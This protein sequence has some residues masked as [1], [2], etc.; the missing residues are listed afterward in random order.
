MAIN[1]LYIPLFNIEEVILDKDSGLPLAAGVVKFY[2]DSQRLTPK[3]V[4]QIAG[5]SPNYS[6]VSLG[7]ELTLGLSGT[8]V[9]Q[10]GDPMVPYAYPYDSEGEVDLYYVTV[11]S[12]GGIP[13][14]VRQA[15][16]H[17]DTGGISPA[18]RSSTENELS[19]PQFVEVNIPETGITTI[20]VTGSN[21]V[22]PVAPGW[23]IISTGTGT[24][25]LERLQPTSANVPTNPPFALRI[26]AS[27]GLGASI[28]LRQR[29]YNTT[30]IFRGGFASGSLTAAVIS[31]GG[32]FVTMTYAPSSGTSTEI[33]PSTSI[34]TD[35][36]YHVIAANAAIPD[37]ANPAAGT[38]Y[39][40][41]NFTLPTSRNLA[42]TSLQVVGTATSINIPYDEQPAARQ[43][44]HLF[45]YYEN[46]VVRQSK[47]SFVVGWNF[48]LNPWQLYPTALTTLTSQT[49]YTADQTIIHQATASSIKT[50]KVGEQL[51]S[52][53]GIRAI[54]GVADNRFALIQYIDPSSVE[55]YWN[56]IVSSLAKV[57]LYTTHSTQ[58]R[59]KMRLIAR[60]SLP[61]TISNTEPISS[62]PADSDPVFGAGWTAIAPMND[63]AYVLSNQT[64]LTD[65][66]A[67]DYPSFS[68]DQFNLPSYVPTLTPTG[69]NTLGVLIYTMDAMNN[70]LGTEDTIIF[71]DV[72][73]CANLF[74][75]KTQAQTY[76][77]VLRQCQFYYEKS[78]SKGVL[79]GA[80]TLDGIRYASAPLGGDYS[81]TTLYKNS[82]Q[83]IFNQVKRAIPNMFF[84]APDGTL[85]QVRMGVWNGTAYPAPGA[86]SNPVNVPITGWDAGSPISATPSSVLL[87]PVNATAI[88]SFAAV[89]GASQG[90]IYY[91]YAASALLGL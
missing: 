74:G 73:L 17:I 76:D 6:F 16:P 13:Q 75:L 22:T 20:S 44:D 18:D 36:G 1:P 38:G 35:G 86:G 9:D 62:W 34:P 67:G 63:P 51:G 15:V 65:K 12:E 59:I 68:F 52:G 37:Q 28:T 50:V 24:L 27:S 7:A 84:Y 55:P 90:E 61:S 40:D 2:R 33:I 57:G 78:Y 23:D 81:S 48:G 47:N 11:E 3:P 69:T 39:I 71:D 60:T 91:H 80:A 32:S 8:F 64:D 29:L 66:T 54:N 19:N 10:D 82:F 31:G 43:K 45:H 21:T 56:S 70:T 46:S 14:F 53:L 89:P 42:I 87:Q 4:F 72:S 5:T 49:A 58:I 79:N 30:S 85:N 41:I 26:S 77:E 83:L 25:T 88:M